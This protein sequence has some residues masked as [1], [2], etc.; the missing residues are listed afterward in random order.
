MIRTGTGMRRRRQQLLLTLMAAVL[1]CAFTSCGNGGSSQTE[2]TVAPWTPQDEQTEQRVQLLTPKQSA[3]IISFSADENIQSVRLGCQYYEHGKLI[4]DDEQVE[5]EFPTE[6]G[7]SKASEGLIS[8][9]REGKRLD[10]SASC[11]GNRFSVSEIELPGYKD[12]DEDESF[13]VGEL[14]EEVPFSDGEPVCLLGYYNTEDGETHAY[15][16][17]T[18]ME[19]PEALKA[20]EKTWIVYAVFSGKPL[21]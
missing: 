4:E 19:D 8:I 9:L 2:N 11:N 12:N 21:D 14:T 1:I 3:A 17:Q 5:Y 16:P 7:T 20:N 18:V 6:E 13:A 15:D 10:I